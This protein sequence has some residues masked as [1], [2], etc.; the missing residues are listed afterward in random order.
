MRRVLKT[1]GRP[2][3]CFQCRENFGAA[4]PF[5]RERVKWLMNVTIQ[6]ENAAKSVLRYTFEGVWDWHDF[7]AAF[8]QQREE[9]SLSNL[10][11]VIDLRKTLHFPSD[12]VLH[13]RRMAELA[14]SIS[15]I[16]IVIATSAPIVT[17][18]QVFM[19]IYHS[20][21]DKFHIASS[22]EEVYRILGL[23]I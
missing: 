16:M 8:D 20:V 7:H 18:F 6:W 19:V 17:I 14:N 22:D 12:A 4:L 11:I 1:H 5:L 21:S 13:L 9:F 2:T 3:A 15:G 23:S 10:C